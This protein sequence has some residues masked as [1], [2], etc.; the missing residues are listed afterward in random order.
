MISELVV[1]NLLVSLVAVAVF[2]VTGVLAGLRKG[3][4]LFSLLVFGL[5]T[6]LGGGT[7]RDM[8]LNVH[9]FWVQN[10]VFVWVAVVASFGTFLIY[11]HVQRVYKLLL[12]LDALGVALFTIQAMN[13]VLDLGHPATVA[14]IMG[15]VT[16]IGGGLVRDVLTNRPTLLMS[17]ELYATPIL[18]GSFFYLF[19]LRAFPRFEFSW[20]LAMTL[21]FA[22]R[23]SVIYWNL[24]MPE[25]LTARREV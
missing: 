14:V 10:V 18:V 7:I 1:Y 6:S 19:L 4:D 2:A 5:V 25:W 21:I 16:G 9:V 11:P 15:V 8:I 13:K 17:R 3:S 23:A 12:Y 22:F 20:L 24:S